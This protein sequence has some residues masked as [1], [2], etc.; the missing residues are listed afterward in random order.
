M[1]ELK[2]KY[3]VESAELPPFGTKMSYVQCFQLQDGIITMKKSTV[4][5]CIPLCNIGFQLDPNLS[6]TEL[7][8]ALLYQTQ[9][10]NGHN[11]EIVDY[12]TTEDVLHTLHHQDEKDI[13]LSP[14]GRILHNCLTADKTYISEDVSLLQNGPIK[15]LTRL[16]HPFC[17]INNNE[18]NKNNQQ[19]SCNY[20][21][22]L[23]NGST[24]H[25]KD[26]YLCVPKH[27]VIFIHLTRLLK[28]TTTNVYLVIAP[29]RE[30]TVDPLIN[31]PGEQ[32]TLHEQ[33]ITVIP[34][35]DEE[36]KQD[37]YHQAYSST[38]VFT[39]EN[40][41]STWVMQNAIERC[42]YYTPAFSLAQ[43]SYREIAVIKLGHI[44]SHTPPPRIMH[45]ISTSSQYFQFDNFIFKPEKWIYQTFAYDN[46]LL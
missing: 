35:G 3:S 38:F 32:L 10:Y 31:K 46:S 17:L 1:R 16:I 27:Q 24:K 2:D 12:W 11:I 45:H 34:I 14:L 28:R 8:T 23:L 36:H 44:P 19:L 20:V 40:A 15:Q 21:V 5:N 7:T 26:T 43:K 37:T 6:Q 39:D 9:H 41:T 13:K 4:L 25:I 33:T 29:Y 30:S 18:N 22:G 42:I